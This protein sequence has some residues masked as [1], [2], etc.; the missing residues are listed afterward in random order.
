LGPNNVRGLWSSAPKNTE[1]LMIKKRFESS[2]LRGRTT[3]DSERWGYANSPSKGIPEKEEKK[4]DLGRIRPLHANRD[5]GGE[6][7]VQYLISLTRQ[8]GGKEGRRSNRKVGAIP[9]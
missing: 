9:P 6:R 1:L 7:A 2:G 3:T 8:R 4:G 5:W